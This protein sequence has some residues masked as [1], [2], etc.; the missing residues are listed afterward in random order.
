MFY[1]IF[2]MMFAFYGFSEDLIISADEMRYNNKTKQSTAIGNARA[3][4]KKK[5]YVLTAHTFLMTR[6]DVKGEE[7]SNIQATGSVFFKTADY[8]MKADACTYE[9][10]SET[11]VCNGNIS[12]HDLKKGNH[13]SG[14]EAVFDIQQ[15]NYTMKGNCAEKTETIL[16]LE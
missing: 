3:E 16:K 4:F 1:A 6:S 7:Y 2:F 14:H 12:L 10:K 5:Q 11:I 9:K 8:E 15:E 13:I